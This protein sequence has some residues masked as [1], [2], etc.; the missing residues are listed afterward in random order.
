MRLAGSLNDYAGFSSRSE[1]LNLGNEGE[2]YIF[3]EDRSVS[4]SEPFGFAGENSEMTGYDNYACRIEIT[5]TEGGNPLNL[6]G[7]DRGD[8]I[9]PVLEMQFDSNIQN[10]FT[11][12]Y[13]EWEESYSD[14]ELQAF[15]N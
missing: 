3:D 5:A 9:R 2:H 7:G 11:D 13:D 4:S 6:M 12:H 14:G 10:E 8:A 15:I 1:M